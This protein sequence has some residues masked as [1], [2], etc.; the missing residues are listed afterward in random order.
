MKIEVYSKADC[1]YCV[2]AKQLLANRGLS[3]NE[4]IISVGMN[5]K[6]LLENQQY[7]TRTSFLEKNPKAKTVPQIWIDDKLIGGFDQ[8]NEY[9]N[10]K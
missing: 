10:N 1:V 4:Y 9:F 3:Y 2:K 8:L 7:I 6:T 5:E